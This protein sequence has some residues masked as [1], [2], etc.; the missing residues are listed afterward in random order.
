MYIYTCYDKSTCTAEHKHLRTIQKIFLFVP[1][2]YV[3]FSPRYKVL[4]ILRA[5]MYECVCVCV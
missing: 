3:N 5:D 2:R 4:K 1:P